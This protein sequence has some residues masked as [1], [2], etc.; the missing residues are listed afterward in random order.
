VLSKTKSSL[1]KI[2]KVVQY[3]KSIFERE[4]HPRPFSYMLKG[5]V[6]GVK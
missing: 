6:E 3:K 4:G 5:G 2:K 1:P